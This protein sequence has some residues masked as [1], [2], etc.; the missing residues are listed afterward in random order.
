MPLAISVVIPAF[1]AEKYIAEALQ[2]VISQTYSPA[3]LIVIDDGSTDATAEIVKQ[4]DRVLYTRQEN[5]GVA[6]ALNHG[7][8]RAAG[9]HIAF[10]SADDVWRP[11]KLERQQAASFER[12]SDLIFGHML[13]FLSPELSA[14]EARNLACPKEPMPAYSAGT[15]LAPR[16][17]FDRVGPFD[18]NF[19]VGEFIDWYGRAKDMGTGSVM[20]PV[21][22]SDRR[23]HKKN[24]STI[25]LKKKS[26]A[27]VLKAL[28]DRRRAQG[29]I[30]QAKK[31]TVPGS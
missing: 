1:N 24:R 5:A 12:P 8:R 19:E 18:E 30:G 31:G 21:V 6:S 10:I 26:Y 11:D 27:P 25:S 22:V 9:S 17:V 7:I 28:L 29:A 15:L 13:N 23:I 3:E 16:E 2:S 4:Y 20:L 14:E